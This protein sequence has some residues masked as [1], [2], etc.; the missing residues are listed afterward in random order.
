[1]APRNTTGTFLVEYV[2]DW[3]PPGN[4]NNVAHMIVHVVM[5]EG[6]I[7]LLWHGSFKPLSECE[8][9]K[10]SRIIPYSP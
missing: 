7:R 5:H 9:W 2:G 10:W 3:F 6:D 8:D 4:P 1:M